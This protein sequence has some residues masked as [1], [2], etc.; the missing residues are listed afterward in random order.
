MTV[1]LDANAA[2]VDDTCL[3]RR[4]ADTATSVDFV[5]AEFEFD[6]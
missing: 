3:L 1:Q 6:A 4:V 2:L 5:L